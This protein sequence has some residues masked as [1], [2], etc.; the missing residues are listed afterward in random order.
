MTTN[1]KLSLR[2]FKV[3]VIFRCPDLNG[4]QKYY[5]R[6]KILNKDRT[7]SDKMFLKQFRAQV[8]LSEFKL[9]VTHTLSKISKQFIVQKYG[10][11]L[12]ERKKFMDQVREEIKQT[13]NK[14][15]VLKVE[16]REFDGAWYDRVGGILAKPNSINALAKSLT[17]NDPTKTKKPRLPNKNYL[18]IEL[19]F[20]NNLGVRT[21][22]IADKLKAAGLAKY[23]EVGTDPSCG[24]EVRV[25][26]QEENFEDPLQKIMKVIT[27]MGFTAHDNCGTHVHVD[28]RNRDVKQVYKNLVYT[29]GFLRKFLTR[30]R[31]RNKFCK[32]NK[33]VD[34]DEQSEIQKHRDDRYYGINVQSYPRHRTLEVRM[35]HGTLDPLVLIPF[36][37][38]LTKIV[39]HKEGLKKPVNTL[40]QARLEYQI[41]PELNS[42]LAERIGTLFGRV[43]T[44]GA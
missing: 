31:K 37:K 38:M 24:F 17:T 10:H 33:H 42:K 26:L 29:Q 36:V 23:V 12:I 14:L 18:G 28:M 22:V 11:D 43:F 41:E 32:L 4:W 27:D 40:K 16:R 15:K 35:H 25:L 13:R 6:K 1:A 34:F 44:N 9:I 21:T 39:N 30:D 2:H 5:A 19:E 20:N 7:E 8:K 3:K